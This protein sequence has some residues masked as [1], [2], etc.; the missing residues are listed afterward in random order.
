MGADVLQKR[1]PLT[2]K[3]D[4][5]DF[6]LTFI[7][8]ISAIAVVTLHTN[9]C[10][11][12]FSATERYWF[13]AN[14]IESVFYFA[15]PVFFMVTGI[16]LLD[17]QE[18]YSTKQFFK[19]RFEKTVIPYIAWSL[20]GVVFLLLMREV[21]LDDLSAK[22]II[23]G[24]LSTNGIIDLY[25]FFQPLFCAYLAIPIFAAIDK[26]KKQRIVGYMIQLALIVNVT[27][28]FFNNVLQLGL[29]WTYQLSVASGY[30]LYVLG[31]WYIYHFP[32]TKEQ[33]VVIVVLGVI[34]LLAHIIGTYSLSMRAGSIQRV[35]KGYNN[36]PCVLYSFAVFQ[37]MRDISGWVKSL[38]PFE[39]VINF[40]GKYTFPLY[41]LQWFL[42]RII[43]KLALFDLKIIYYRLLGPYLILIV[44]VGVTW[45]LRKIPVLKRIVP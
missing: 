38:P 45:F 11:W 43:S 4:S 31:G 21:K 26:E 35:Y 18:R 6:G 1:I 32:P 15:V 9:G 16:T 19:K 40:L 12:W 30:L 24:L 29:T 22:W 44:V 2:E 41:L 25:W 17:Y 33:K 28:P 8:V 13:T 5:R 42:L 34:G 23:N 39:T 20:V 36:L 10:F 3:T 27:V 14:I 37:I 7:Q